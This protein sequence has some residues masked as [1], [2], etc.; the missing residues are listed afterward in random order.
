MYKLFTAARSAGTYAHGVLCLLV[1]LAVVQACIPVGFMPDPAALAQGRWALMLCPAAGPRPVSRI[2]V[3]EHGHRA[4]PNNHADA[5][6]PNAHTDHVMHVARASSEE[7]DSHLMHAS[8]ASNEA[9]DGR[10]MHA[11]HASSEEHDGRFMHASG[12]SSQEHEGHDAQP[13]SLECPYSLIA[14]LTGDLP[15]TALTIALL[16]RAAPDVATR[17][18]QSR[19]PL[20][21]A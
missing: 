6:V 18:P 14:N 5:A 13:A 15:P 21:P 8:R 2:A 20:P 4:D 16:P 17:V 11:S 12:A 1:M 10:F 9:H 7:H 19:P 3:V